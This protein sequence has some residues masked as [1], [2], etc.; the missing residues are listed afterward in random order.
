MHLELGFYQSKS[1][2]ETSTH[3]TRVETLKGGR[4]QYT[5]IHWKTAWWRRF[6]AEELTC[7]S[8]HDGGGLGGHRRAPRGVAAEGGRGEERDG[9][10]ARVGEDN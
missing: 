8:K 4:E 3:Q 5:V 10:W 6:R 2:I 7:E 1:S 9:A